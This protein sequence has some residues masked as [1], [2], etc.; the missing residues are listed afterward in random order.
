MES[1]LSD[2][3]SSDEEGNC[4]GDEATDYADSE[5]EG[6][7]QSE[8]VE[9]PEP[10]SLITNQ[11]HTQIIVL[12]WQYK[13]YVSDNAIE[14]LLKFVQQLLFC[15][16]HLIKDHT[17][18]CLVLAMNLPTTLYSARK[19][20]KIN[21]DNFQQYVVCLKCTKLYHMDEIVINDGHR[22]VARTCSSVAFPRARRLKVCGSQLA[23]K[24]SLKNGNVK[25]Y[26]LKT[27]CYRSI[28]DS[29]ETLLK[30]P[31]LEEQCEKWRTRTIKDDLYADVYDGKI[32]KQFGNWN[33]NKP[34]LDLPRSFGLMMNVDWFKPFKHRN[35]FSVGVIYMVLMNLPRRIRFKK[36][37]VILGG[38][39]PALA[40]EP[41]SL[42]HFLE[43]AVSELNAL[44]K[45]VKVNTFNSTSVAVKIQAAVLYF[46]SDIP[47][48][49]KLCCFLGH[50]AKRGCSH[51][52]KA[53][54]GGFGEQRDY[55]GFDDRD[56][57]PKTSS[58]QHR[59]DAYRVKNCASDTA[60]GKLAR[61]LGCRYT[62][63]LELPY[64]SS[65]EMCVIDPMHNLFL[66]TAKRVFSKWIENDI[67]TK[68]GL[69]TIQSKIDEMFSL[70]DI[71]RLPG[72]IKSNYGGYTAAQWKNFVLFEGC[73][74]IGTSSLLAIVCSSLSYVV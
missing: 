49:R 23:Q 19:L 36:E 12:L 28:I 62:V 46:A 64:Y 33:G 57:W 29:L 40:H 54:P 11:Q 42:N 27:Y 67:I 21:R 50:S 51:C 31:G 34:F 52:Y 25:F 45:G 65:V 8:E 70:S 69:E 32:W 9:L 15:I 47:A 38:V 6:I 18:L 66:G 17:E 73:P 74:S 20:L 61:E 2:V 35:D 13:N 60:A 43:P 22:S 72:I 24:V 41:K 7:L 48:A 55:S 3:T 5:D 10:S 56:Q 16:G 58:E 14:Q 30:R 53:F 26:A 63:L 71:G 68:A 44:W 4:S 39:I 1:H 59:R 37:N